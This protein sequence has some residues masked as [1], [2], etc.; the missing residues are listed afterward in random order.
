MVNV[1]GVLADF[2]RSALANSTMNLQPEIVFRP[3]GNAVK[4]TGSVVYVTRPLKVPPAISTGAWTADLEPT[5]GLNPEVWYEITIRW[6][7]RRRH[8][9]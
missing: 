1:T 8:Y 6:L 9:Q 2:G 3:S 7:D 4:A 5:T